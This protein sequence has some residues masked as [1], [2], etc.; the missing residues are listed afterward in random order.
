MIGLDPSAAMLAIARE[1]PG[2]D[3]VRWLEG[4]VT[5][6]A[7]LGD[8]RADLAIMSGH[9]AQF[10]LTDDAWNEALAAI[11][12]ALRPGGWL[13]FETRNPD[14]RG[15][16]EW[17]PAAVRSVDDPMAGRVDTWT[18]V[19]DVRDGVVSFANHY[20]FVDRRDEVVSPAQL[21]F[22]TEGEVRRS[23]EAAGFTV[24][25]IHGDWDGGPVGPRA[26]ELVVVARTRRGRAR[27]PGL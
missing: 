17:T 18:E 15:W 24:E 13:A 22:R 20:R 26:P 21:R 23:L 16:E 5:E 6:L 25:R 4:P 11:E 8:D 3:R 14:A 10:F 9:V 12:A 27:G 7:Q 1:R 2:G 19:D